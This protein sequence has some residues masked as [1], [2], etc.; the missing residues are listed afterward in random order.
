MVFAR[1]AP[2]RWRWPLLWLTVQ[3]GV[4]LLYVPWISIGVSSVIGWS[5]AGGS[6]SLV[7]ALLDV[8]RALGVGITIQVEEA[9]V[10]L[11]V[12]VALALVGLWPRGYDRTGWVGVAVVALYLLLPL[13]LILALDL[14]KPAWLKFLIVALPPFHLLVG[15]GIETLARRTGRLPSVGKWLG[16]RAVRFV[17]YG[18]VAATV[19]PSL[20][21]LYF[22]PAYAR[23][24]YRQIAADVTA[25]VRED[26]AIVLNAPNQ[27]EVFTYYYPDENV[28]PAPYTPNED[29]A[30]D[31]LLPLVDRHR[32][33]FVL[34]WG[35]DES[36][37][38]RLIE[39]GLAAWAYKASDRWYGRV[40]LATYGT[41]PLP[42]EP[43][44]TSGAD[45]GGHIRLLGFSVAGDAHAPGT[46]VPVTLFWQASKV[47]PQRYKVTV[48]LLDPTGHL[49]TQNDSEPLDGLSPTTAWEPGTRII[50]RYGLPV[51]PSLAEGQYSLI[52][53]VYHAATGERLPASQDGQPLGDHLRLAVVGLRP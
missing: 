36:D 34:Y 43:R 38:Q 37:P 39:S 29:Q 27:W 20:V 50:D 35:D 6:Y 7:L 46:I 2:D 33:L 49:V 5:P 1:K 22:G 28:H 13:A 14:Y 53:A 45:F 19:L 47:V 24:D 25:V 26:D 16:P 40:R 52:L 11:A 4:L 17:G 23:D 12:L 32:R 10:A 42:A 15:H 51:P 30:R 8:L 21:N 31:F 48:Q 9:V 3:V 44:V 41:G 18:C